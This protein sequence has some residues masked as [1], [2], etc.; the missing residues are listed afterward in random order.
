MDTFQKFWVS[1]NELIPIQ[2]RTVLNE[3][4]LSLKLENKA[5]ST[6]LKYRSTLEK[7][8]S[9]CHVN[10]EDLTHKDVLNWLN[11]YSQGKKP[12]TI[13]FYLSVISSFFNFCLAEGYMGKKVIKK[14][15]RPK[16]PESL[17]RYLNEQE[18]ARVKVASERMSIRDRALVLFLF[19]SGCRRSEVA[20]LSIQ[21]IDF[22]Q[23]TAKVRGKGKK[24]RHIHFSVECA[25]V[26]K[27]YLHYRSYESTEPLFMNRFGRRLQPYSIY[28]VTRKL[29]EM[30]D[31]LQILHP[32]CCRHTFATKMLARG[33]DI[34]FI[35]DE[36][37]H[38]DLNTTRI[39]ARIPT[40]D[41]I[42]AYQNRMG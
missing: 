16:L 10:L 33:A 25:H 4:L 29:G 31:L 6:I 41:L 14:R 11:E 9:K 17:P 37:G 12:R 27:D 36:M 39:Y 13:D 23:H 8:L 15:W 42:L 22:A 30:G 20:N 3:Y 32:H 40:E 35:A 1:T 34:Q 19:S 38:A 26:L 24:I 7:V 5:E 28:K 18:F 2:T 21:D